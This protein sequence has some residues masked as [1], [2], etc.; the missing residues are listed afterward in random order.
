M[1]TQSFKLSPWQKRQAALLY[2]FA[3]TPYLK[4]VKQAVDELILFANQTLDLASVEDRD[5]ML[6]SARWG[7]RNTSQNWGNNAWPFLSDFQRSL[8]G[9]IAKRDV[10]E[11]QVTGRNQC[12]RGMAEFS[13]EWATLEEQ[14]KFDE[15]FAVISETAANIDET[16][17]RFGG[18]SPWSDFALTLAWEAH[19]LYFAQ[20]PMLRVREDIYAETGA[21]PAKTGVYFCPSD[22]NLSLQF[23]WHGGAG[24]RLLKG[25]TF[26]ALGESALASV[27]RVDLWLDGK[28]MLEFVN[29]NL[30]SGYFRDE[31]DLDYS[32][33]EVLAPSLVAR[34]A[35]TSKTCRWY[36]IEL[37]TGEFEESGELEAARDR[38]QPETARFGAGEHC[39]IMGFYFTPARHNSRRFFNQNELFPDESSSYGAT[40]WQF[41]TN[42]Q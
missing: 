3:S 5:T 17:S 6:R 18:E 16:I 9:D 12:A 1:T 36:Y 13:M 2:H 39:P 15:L 34:N 8:A 25:S 10:E 37:V 41:D 21:V 35:F 30:E 7:D 29:K 38:H 31:D 33:K 20:L 32:R 23:A 40:I 24:G 42:Q 28:K 14:R 11:F 4:N 26:N 22:S 27:G 19:K